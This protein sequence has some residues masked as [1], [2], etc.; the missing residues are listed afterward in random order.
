MKTAFAIENSLNV[1]E[2][3]SSQI[4]RSKVNI[5]QYLNMK[6]MYIEE[7]TD[8]SLLVVGKSVLMSEVLKLVVKPRRYTKIFAD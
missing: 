7:L 6:S 8:K 1:I 5:H 4:F 3:S 2:K